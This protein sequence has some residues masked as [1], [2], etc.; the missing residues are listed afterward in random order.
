MAGRQPGPL[1]CDLGGRQRF[2]RLRCDLRRNVRGGF[3]SHFRSRFRRDFSRRPAVASRVAASVASA[4]GSAP[5]AVGRFPA[6]GTVIAAGSV[7]STVASDVASAVTSGNSVPGLRPSPRRSRRV[8]P[9][10]AASQRDRRG[11]GVGWFTQSLRLWRAA[12][13]ASVAASVGS[14]GQLA[15]RQRLC[16]FG[17][18][19]S[20]HSVKSR[21]PG[22]F[23][24]AA[25]VASTGGAAAS[26]VASASGACAVITALSSAVAGPHATT[27]GWARAGAF[28]PPLPP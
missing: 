11:R 15:G 12:G 17:G 4:V 22:R 10:R 3:R 16:G 14:G 8:L 1:R 28:R 25:A 13:T 9:S 6:L 18:L 23:S 2:G 27:A 26:S 21:Q 24:V 19:R 7:A 20:W 5:V